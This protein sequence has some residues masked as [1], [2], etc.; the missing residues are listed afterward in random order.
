MH[1]PR[2]RRA[3]DDARQ[4]IVRA[5][6]VGRPNVFVTLDEADY[7]ALIAARGTLRFYLVQNRV[8]GPS[9][10]RIKQHDVLGRLTLVSRA[11]ANPGRGQIV[12]YRNEDHLDLRRRNLVVAN[13]GK[14]MG[15]TPRFDEFSG[16][17]VEQTRRA[18]KRAGSSAVSAVP[19]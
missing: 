19:A 11:I 10:V 18:A 17:T 13:G 12:R 1:T 3:F 15:P 4:P 7:D 6:I 2:V 8:D 9:Y 14:R 5:E 16:L